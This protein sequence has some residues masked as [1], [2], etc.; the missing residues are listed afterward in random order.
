MFPSL[1][2]T[3]ADSQD[4]PR[5]ATADMP[6][7]GMNTR[8]FLRNGL[9][10]V[11]L[12]LLIYTI[13]YAATD[14][15]IYRYAKRNRFY[16]VKTAPLSSYD[17]VI[18]GAS[19][20]A[21]F[22]YEDMNARLEKMTG[23]RILN[24]S[25][26]GAGVEVNRVVLEYF[27]IRHQT[28]GVVYVADSFAFLTDEWNSKRFQDVRL[29]AR[30]PFDPALFHVLLRDPASRSAAWNYLVGFSKINYPDRFKPDITDDEATRFNKNYRPV[31]QIDMQR[32]KF[33]Y[34]TESDPEVLRRYLA[35]FEDMI[36]VLKGRNI[37]LIVIKPPI[38]ARFYDMLPD[39]AHFDESLNAVLEKNGIEFHDFSLVGNDEK[40]FFNPDHLNRAGVLNFYERYLKGI[41]AR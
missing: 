23:K 5:E 35:E 41:L 8:R 25:A 18:L 22:D 21:V 1:L 16:A 34:P 3:T 26:V 39:E 29:F 40:Y 19:H 32:I 6:D 2:S 17:Y 20:A 24:L 9:V 27:L 37:R 10:F 33:L 7:N 15:L 12:G 4:A 30:A 36:R 11:L 28:R 38:P 14:H 13:L 31:K